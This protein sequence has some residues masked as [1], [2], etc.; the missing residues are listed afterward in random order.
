MHL[1][2]SLIRFNS[3]KHLILEHP[4]LDSMLVNLD[5]L[6]DISFEFDSL[7][8]SFNLKRNDVF[9][10]LTLT[11]GVQSSVIRPENNIIVSLNGVLQEPGVGFEIVGSRI[12]FSEIPRLDLHSL[13]SL[14]SVLKQ[15][16]RLLKLFLQLNLVTSLR[17]KVRLPIEKLLY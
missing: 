5:N 13:H 2:H 4:S 11:D 14:M 17:F 8:Q 1:Q 15:T 3:L 9:Y 6:D 7:S 16:L 10:S 12:I